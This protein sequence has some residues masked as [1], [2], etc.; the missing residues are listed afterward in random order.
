MEYMGF[1]LAET[2]IRQ[3]FNFYDQDRSNTIELN[4]FMNI[5]KYLDDWR[6]CHAFHALIC[7]MLSSIMIRIDLVRWK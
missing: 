3:Q 5:H 1:N 2:I 6:V 4:E 7:R